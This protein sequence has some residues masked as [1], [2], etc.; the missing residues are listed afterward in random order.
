[1]RPL[2]MHPGVSAITIVHTGSAPPAIYGR[3]AAEFSK[4]TEIHRACGEGYHL[5]VDDGGYDQMS[6]R[7][8]GLEKIEEKNTDWI[9]Q[10][11]ADELLT[12]S[13]IEV[14]L[15]A[16]DDHDIVAFDYHTPLSEREFWFEPRILRQVGRETLLDPHLLIWRSRLK[17][18]PALCEKTAN[19]SLN[20]TRHCSVSFP[21]F[22]YWRTLTAKGLFFFH[23][24]CILSK[25]NTERR[26]GVA[27]FAEPLPSEVVRCMTELQAFSNNA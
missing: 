26:R 6:A 24:H 23:F 5:S 3:L 15:S 17:K 2:L 19:I 1:M 11:D 27:P 22:P 10:L 13:A 20:K 7:L 25:E 4:V 21:N 14:I 16:S 18:R 12:S 9:I 8:F